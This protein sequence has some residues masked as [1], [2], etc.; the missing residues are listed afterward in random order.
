M[1]TKKMMIM[2]I[3]MKKVTFKLQVARKVKRKPLKP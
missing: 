3:M 2:I 1:R